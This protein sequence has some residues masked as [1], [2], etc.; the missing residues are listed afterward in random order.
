MRLVGLGCEKKFFP[1][2]KASTSTPP[3]LFNERIDL[4]RNWLTSSRYVIELG[5][6]FSSGA[7]QIL[8]QRNEP[9]CN[10][11]TS[12]YTPSLRNAA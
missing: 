7:N 4:R 1:L 10:S 5:C 3:S 6:C 2:N 12:V 11:S 9:S 8:P